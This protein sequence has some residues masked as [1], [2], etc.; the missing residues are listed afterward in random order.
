MRTLNEDLRDLIL[1]EDPFDLN[2]C[3]RPCCILLF[4]SGTGNTGREV[5]VNLKEN[6][7]CSTWC[8][9]SESEPPNVLVFPKHTQLLIFFLLV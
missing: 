9:G 1:S 3:F 8:L 5:L 2:F 6:V 7:K 4:N